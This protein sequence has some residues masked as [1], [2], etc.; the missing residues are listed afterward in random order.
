MVVRICDRCKRPIKNQVFNERYVLQERK[1]DLLL[2]SVELCPKC[3]ESLAFWMAKPTSPYGG[4]G[5]GSN[6]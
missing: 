2:V 5:D 1:P 4:D 3:Q 6:V